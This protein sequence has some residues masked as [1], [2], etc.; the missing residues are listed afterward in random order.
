VTGV[1]GVVNA[2]AFEYH[3]YFAARQK[4]DTYACE[5]Q[6]GVVE[7]EFHLTMPS[8]EDKKEALKRGSVLI[9]NYQSSLR[10]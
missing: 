2:R 5:S 7:A 3:Q 1:Q 8:F 4:F 6:F 10:R 9:H